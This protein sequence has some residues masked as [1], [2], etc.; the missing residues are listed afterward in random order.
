MNKKIGKLRQLEMFKP[1]QG[2]EKEAL[3][4]KVKSRFD[5]RWLIL[6]LFL[7]S[8][9]ASLFFYL[10]TEI[11]RW[12]Q[13]IFST[14]VI[15]SKLPSGMESS[16]SQTIA[17]LREKTQ[18]LQGEYGIYIYELENGWSYG[19]NQD[20]VFPAASLIKLPIMIRAYQ[21]SES[22]E[23]DLEETYFL[24]ETD[25]RV[26]AGIL[27]SQAAGTSYTYRELIR[28]MAHYSDNTAAKIISDLLGEG[29]IEAAIKDIGMEKTTFSENETTP[30]DIGLL[31]K[32]LYQG[33]LISSEN[34]DELL[35]FLTETAFE[36]RIPAGLPEEVRVAHKIGTETASFSDAA[37]ILAEEPFILV[38]MSRGALES[39]AEKILVEISRLVWA[40]R[41]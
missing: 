21:K 22:G 3:K 39:E 35:D 4:K 24:K 9:G 14:E 29:E 28:L 10:R 33:E 16:S 31:L 23:L 32:K 17:K 7:V 12:L 25:K 37:I 30:T 13:E 2:E 1:P 41:V 38:I 36:D 20:L 5:G 18:G 11:P 8:L 26:G 40:S 15:I 34:R 27:E 6:I 19:L